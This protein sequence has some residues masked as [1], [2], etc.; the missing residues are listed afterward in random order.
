MCGFTNSTVRCIHRLRSMPA[1]SSPSPATIRRVF[2]ARLGMAKILKL[3]LFF[4]GPLD[5][6]ESLQELPGRRGAWS[7]APGW[8]TI[9]VDESQVTAPGRTFAKSLGF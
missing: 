3:L 8:S 1:L 4:L 9:S 7:P 5:R 6:R 2:S